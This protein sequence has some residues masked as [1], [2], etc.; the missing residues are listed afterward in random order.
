MALE[1]EIAELEARLQKLDGSIDSC[2]SESELNRIG[3]DLA[4]LESELTP[5]REAAKRHA[6][7]EETLKDIEHKIARKRPRI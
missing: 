6:I 3:S 2:R 1:K 7:L 4:A 5:M